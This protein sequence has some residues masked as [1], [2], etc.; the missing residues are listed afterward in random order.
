MA[1]VYQYDADGLYLYP[2]DDYNGPMPHNCTATAPPGAAPG[3][4]AR[5]TGQAW[6]PVEDYRGRAA[7]RPDGES[8]TVKDWGPLPE[9]DS[10]EPPPPTPED[11]AKT[12]IGEIKAAFA[13]IASD[14]ER[15][16]RALKVAELRGQPEPQADKE[17]LIDLEARAEELRA[18]L[19]A[20]ESEVQN[21]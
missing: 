15:P 8:Y 1:I 10:L 14:S 3:R 4:R 20:L 13:R 6:E 21:D 5:W 19:A 17:K 18:E 7:Y 12:R 9:G 11:E 16:L 2:A